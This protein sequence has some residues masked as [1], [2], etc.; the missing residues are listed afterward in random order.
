[1]AHIEM[2]MATIAHIKEL[3]GQMCSSRRRLK[4]ILAEIVK[5][6]DDNLFVDA[7]SQEVK[8]LLED[9]VQMQAR[10]YELDGLK[11]AAASKNVGK[12]ET[13]IT[14]L[15]KK[16]TANEIRSI[17]LRFE[18]LKCSSDEANVIEDIQKLQRQARKLYLS[19]DK[20]QM[21]VD[22]FIVESQKFIDLANNL[23]N[24]DKMSS[25]DFKEMQRVFS[26]ISSLDFALLRNLLTL[27]K[28]DEQPK[29]EAPKKAV[30]EAKAQA[31]AT[32]KVIKQFSVSLDQ[33][34]ENEADFVVENAEVKKKLAFKAF[35]NKLNSLTEGNR[36]DFN[37]LLRN[38]CSNR[39]FYIEKPDEESDFKGHNA[40]PMVETVSNKLFQ[41]GAVSKVHWRELS[42][43]YLNDFGYEYLS[44]IFPSKEGKNHQKK[45]ARQSMTQCIRRFIFLSIFNKFK[46][47]T[48]EYLINGDASRFWIMTK[49]EHDG[50]IRIHMALSL[51]ILPNDW[52]EQVCSFMTS[53]DKEAHGVMDLRA[54]FLITTIDV[55][56]LTPWLKH[57]KKIGAKN[58]FSV[59][60]EGRNL[61]YHDIEGD[62][63]E[64]NDV[65]KY[66]HGDEDTFA[67][68]KSKYIKKTRRGRKKAA[69]E[70]SADVT[71]EKTE[72]VE[73]GKRGK[74]SKKTEKEAAPASASADDD[75]ESTFSLFSTALEQSDRETNSVEENKSVEINKPVDELEEVETSTDETSAD[76]TS[77]EEVSD[78]ATVQTVEEI[79]L[80]TPLELEGKLSLDDDFIKNVMR[81]AIVLFLRGSGARGLLELQILCSGDDLN[82]LSGTE[83]PNE[84]FEWFDGLTKLTAIALGDPSVRSE[85][86]E[87][88][89]LP[90]C[91]E[92]FK[93]HAPFDEL[94]AHYIKNFYA[95]T[96]LL[97]ESYAPD[98]N[99]IYELSNRQMQFLS[100]KSNAALK[101]CPSLKKLI[102]LFKDFTEKH[103]APF[104]SS[105][106]TDYVGVKKQFDAAMKLIENARGRADSVFRN[107]MKHPRVHILSKQLYDVDGV[108]RRKIELQ[109]DDPDS[110]IEFCR[111]FMDEGAT[112]DGDYKKINDNLFSSQ[113]VREYL[114]DVWNAIKVDS[115]RSEKFMGDEQTKQRNAFIQMLTALTSYAVAKMQLDAVGDGSPAPVEQALKLI[116][117]IIDESR[118]MM[119]GVELNHIG[120]ALMIVCLKQLKSLIEEKSE[121]PFYRE[122]LLGTR[123]I[124][125]TAEDL[126]ET[127]NIGALRYSFAC[128][129]FE[130]EQA[131][132]NQTLEEAV[133]AACETAIR[134]Y[135]AGVFIQLEKNY[136]EL[137]NLSDE[138]I[139]QIRAASLNQVG[140]RLDMLYR[141]FMQKLE[142][143]RHYARVIN[144]GDIDYYITAVKS[145]K[146]HFEETNNAGL[147]ERF[148]EALNAGI[149]Q[150]SKANAVE[151]RARTVDVKD[152]KARAFIE[153]L[154]DEG[155]YNVAEDCIN[156]GSGRIDMSVA[157]G[158][159]EFLQSDESIF[160]ACV[161]NKN[162]SLE[163]ILATLK[164]DL[165]DV[166]LREFA[167]AWQNASSK[168]VMLPDLLKYLSFEG[169]EIDELK[170][171]SN[172]QLEFRARFEVSTNELP[173]DIFSADAL[174]F[175]YMPYNMKL[176]EVTEALQKVERKERVMICLLNMALGLA[177]RRKLAQS[178]KLRADLKNI[179]VIDRV[180]AVYLTAFEQ[181]ERRLK[182]LSA[183]L[184]FANANPYEEDSTEIFI[185]REKELE[186]LRDINGATFLVGGRQLGKTAL[187][188]RL[189]KLE[190]R[191]AEGSFVLK[192][193]GDDW[194]AIRAEMVER[195]KSDDV[196][197]LILLMDINK[198]FASSKSY[199]L[200]PFER[201][202]EEYSGR[203][204]FIAT[205]HH[206]SASNDNAIKLKPFTPQEAF[207]FT[208]EPLGLLGFKFVDE[209]AIRSIWVQANYY[210][211]LLKYYCGKTVE[212]IAD[213]Y[214]Q[215]NFDVTKN[216]PYA[217]DDEF[218]QNM[219]RSHGLQDD[220]NRRLIGTLGDE[221]EEYYYVLM[222]SMSYSQYYYGKQ[223]F[224]FERLRDMFVLHDIYDWTNLND[225]AIEFLLEEMIEA[226]L[227]RQTGERYE[228]YREAFRY[229]LG[230]NDKQVE[231]RLKECA[232]RHHTRAAQ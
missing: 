133:Q 19:V 120:A 207:R 85:L 221:Q 89:P 79:F 81:N 180:L 20:G 51:M 37:P 195:L 111:R 217:F 115:H 151:L 200:E 201:L 144:S 208:V 164:R 168:T 148:I 206:T 33:L 22:N 130:Y 38:F 226:K 102:T 155:R 16:S 184:P 35:N 138:K 78:D 5:A 82:Q 203:F 98:M 166:E 6:L 134:S 127:D 149:S 112:F 194:D 169:A 163:K 52:A 129:V 177:D 213:N 118:S 105:L 80:P 123:Y 62:R 42:F 227:I 99:G 106:H 65:F 54:V 39:V 228:F 124:E 215:K 160:S 190:H 119:R 88:M 36:Q 107:S 171:Q 34:L 104:A 161:K 96:F 179:I 153:Q 135:D 97:K 48:R 53:V 156:E 92:F 181:S 108:M 43:Y 1:M 55:K 202:R 198:I 70:A 44:K 211:G 132:G 136:R 23:D 145:A 67:T 220:I 159:N 121:P 172:N 126:P 131:L 94:D 165:N 56:T 15:D 24:P 41:W 182:L 58:V 205:A 12:L 49:I 167:E 87:F 122:C 162:E 30:D 170:K 4:P 222:L 158:L 146:H 174:D 176:D 142:L 47:D 189:I 100:D 14:A 26:D 210:P 75:S 116:D 86:K 143:D 103:K 71:P 178:L 125:L 191:P 84:I 214:N 204:K 18:G 231:A 59:T 216:P 185:G 10:F 64:F 218:L 3:F 7:D 223:D 77:A 69:E 196:K 63:I 8:D 60:L 95:A 232:Q 173:F 183:S 61:E 45:P 219:L 140:R 17:L 101:N 157:D 93:R 11:S 50:I 147:F 139:K 83:M 117:N 28:L 188:E 230:D 197:K 74:K 40:N 2:R 199:E 186:A 225:D 224:T 27:P 128:R 110:L 212:A 154:I 72:A 114:D 137:L 66:L 175:V 209:S 113:K 46:V 91:D 76:E 152:Q 57:F 150:V 25:N 141:E 187:L 21:S 90:Y 68:Y 229:L 192:S 13:A 31:K 73:K 32:D 193:V 29:D 9:I 109:D